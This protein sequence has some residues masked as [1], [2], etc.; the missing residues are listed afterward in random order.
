MKRLMMLV[1]FKL[2]AVEELHH[3]PPQW[4][5]YWMAGNHASTLVLWKEVHLVSAKLHSRMPRVTPNKHAHNKFADEVLYCLFNAG[6]NIADIDN[7]LIA[8]EH[9]VRVVEDYIYMLKEFA[10]T[11]H[12]LLVV[13][14]FDFIVRKQNGRVAKG[15]LVS[16]MI[17]TLGRLGEINL[18]L[19]LFYNTLMDAGAKGQADFD[20]V[21][22]FYDELLGRGIVPDRLTYNSLLSVC[23]PK[24]MWEMA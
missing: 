24:G 23:A 19:R 5:L 14:C 20:V 18:S 17:G 16:T 11:G 7:I 10:N 22:K 21:V 2:F 3:I 6:N 8:Y 13:K 15:K 12:L 4:I 9:K 1:V